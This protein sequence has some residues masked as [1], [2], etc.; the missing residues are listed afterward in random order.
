MYKNRKMRTVEIVVG[1]GKGGI[2]ERHGR[3]DS[4]IYCKNFGNVTMYLCY[5][6]HILIN[7]FLKKI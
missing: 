1:R 7:T 6:C 4:K 3:G 2:K 5:N